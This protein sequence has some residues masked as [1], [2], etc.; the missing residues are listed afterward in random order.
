MLKTKTSKSKG[1]H[2]LAIEVCK[3]EGKKVEVNIAQ[4]KEVLRI[5]GE[6]IL[7]KRI[8]AV[9]A[10]AAKMGSGEASGSIKRPVQR[11]KLSRKS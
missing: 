6:I 1:L 2:A 9:F 8:N 10:Q 3:R 7:E 4:V 5:L 11:K